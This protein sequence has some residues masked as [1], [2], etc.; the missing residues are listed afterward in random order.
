MESL[1]HSL[2]QIGEVAWRAFQALNTRLPASEPAERSW[3]P[4]PLLKSHQRSRPPLG[5]PRETD[6]LCPRCVME[7]RAQ[8]IRGERK[9]SDLVTGHLGEIKATFYEQDNQIR[10][11][12][13]CPEHGTFEDLISIDAEFSRRI[14]PVPGR[15][16]AGRGR[17]AG[18]PRYGTSS[19]KHGRRR[20]DHRPHQPLQHDVQP[21]FHGRQP[22]GLR[23]RAEPWRRSGRSG[24]LHLLQPRRQMSVQFSGGEADPVAALPGRVPVRQEGRLQ[25]GASR[26]QRPALRA[27]A[28]LRRAGEGGRL[29]HCSVPAVRRG[30]PTRPTLT[31]RSRTFSTSRRSP[32]RTCTPPGS[33]S[34]RWSPS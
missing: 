13:T 21:V 5:Y 17:R 18:P 22:G 9:V 7:T 4:G 32:S 16:F 19:I 3:A 8:I 31:A 15:D 25:D 27:G 29:R 26:H 2:Q 33:R 12:K 6:S 34:R 1:G 28:G 23:S 30:A 24:R 10:V 14:E 20:A 11:R